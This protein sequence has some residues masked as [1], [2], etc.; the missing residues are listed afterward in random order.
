MGVCYNKRWKLLIDVKMNKI[1]L[2]KAANISGNVLLRLNKDEFVSMESL[3][4][5]CCTLNC[6]VGD[7]ME[8]NIIEEDTENV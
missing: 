2:Q 4:K 6:D 3:Y 1:E 5:I 7:V 8:F